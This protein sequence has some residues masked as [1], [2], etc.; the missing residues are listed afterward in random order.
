MEN[1]LEMRGILLQKQKYND[2]AHHIINI[3]AKKELDVVKR[4]N[5]SLNKKVIDLEDYAEQSDE[6]IFILEKRL[7]KLEQYTRR[8]NIEISGISHNVPSNQLEDIVIDL[9]NQINVKIDKK[10]IQAC[11]KLPD[12]DNQKPNNV[13]VRFSNRFL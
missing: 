10:D 3:F 5:L 13:I 9:L 2:I 8:E 1:A 4:E 6:Q 7:N 12:I 11:H